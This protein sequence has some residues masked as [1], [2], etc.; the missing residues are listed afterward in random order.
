M[1]RG[2]DTSDLVQPPSQD[3]L[4]PLASS[5]STTP[6]PK[7]QDI[8]MLYRAVVAFAV[9]CASSTSAFML[10]PATGS[11]A[12]S[13]AVN[14]VEVIEM[15][16]GDKRTAKGKRKAKSF[17]VS[18]CA[19]GEIAMGPCRCCSR[20][21][22]VRLHIAS[23]F[24]LLMF[25]PALD[26]PA[27]PGT[28]SC[29]RRRRRPPARSKFAA[30]SIPTPSCGLPPQFAERLQQR[31]SRAGCELRST[32]QVPAQRSCRSGVAGAYR[33]PSAAFEF[34]SVF[35]K[36]NRLLRHMHSQ[37]RGRCIPAPHGAPDATRARPPATHLPCRMQRPE[38]PGVCPQTRREDPECGAASGV[39]RTAG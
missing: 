11:I 25:F 17:G 18:R 21:I 2:P 35:S 28:R 33:I 38:S 29:A 22:R 10:A 5:S 36:L 19:Q 24:P 27:G 12:L 20:E 7:P 1:R 6:S 4:A 32:T 39:T 3:R 13:G 37:P 34:Y 23:A 8:S 14:R 15:G 16:R 30:H 31:F 26:F 9:L